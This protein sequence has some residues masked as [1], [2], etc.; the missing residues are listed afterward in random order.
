MG[1]ARTRPSPTMP[2]LATTI[3]T[4]L[5][6]AVAIAPTGSAAA[7][8]GLNVSGTWHAIYHCMSGKCAGQEKTGTF[9]LAEAAESAAVSGTLS[10]SGGGEGSVSG[11]LSGSTLHLEGSGARGYTASGVETIAADGLSWTGTYADSNGTSGTLTASR[12][13]PSTGAT[14][15]A[16]AIEVICNLNVAPATFTCTAQVGDASAQMPA[17][18]PTGTVMF[19]A[20][21][22]A[23]TPLDS[24]A[25]VPTPASSDVS[26]CS[27]TY[28]PPFGGIP[29]GTPAP[30]VGTYSGDSTF[31][32]STAKSG[33]GPSASASS[34]STSAGGASSTVSCPAGAASCPVTA[35]LSVIQTGSAIAAKRAKR[36]TIVI[37]KTS[38]T[39]QPG[40][41]RTIRVTLDRAGK[42][43]LAGRKSLPA[44]F[45]ISSR[46]K[47]LRTQKVTIRTAAR[48]PKHK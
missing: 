1:A 39:L 42:R 45:K 21:S 6:A 11:N 10:V 12:E 41:K 7:A 30:V 23:F 3:A 15:R 35:E 13:A 14:L 28:V 32:S 47:L 26:S 36:R 34:A 5:L 2:R 43:L 46:G 9:T 8:A 29:T 33:A 17:K 16:S 22:G 24:C 20:A 38:L 37:G 19:T 31:A 48:S 18:V 25:L 27:V 40:Q 4:G 44:L